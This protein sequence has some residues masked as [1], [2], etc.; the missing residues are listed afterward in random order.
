MHTNSTW[1][2]LVKVRTTTD[3]VENKLHLYIFTCSVFFKVFRTGDRLLEYKDIC[4]DALYMLIEFTVVLRFL[5]R[6][7]LF[8]CLNMNI[9]FYFMHY[10]F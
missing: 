2:N 8:F 5:V 3:E 1:I 7:C 4:E 9:V 10:C 6:F